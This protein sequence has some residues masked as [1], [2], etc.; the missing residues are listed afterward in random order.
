[1]WSGILDFEQTQVLVSGVGC[2][3]ESSFGVEWDFEQS[4]VLVSGVRF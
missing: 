1:M 4:Q 2:R 3:A